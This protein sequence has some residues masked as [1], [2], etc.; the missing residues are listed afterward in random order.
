[1]FIDLFYCYFSCSEPVREFFCYDDPPGAHDS[2]EES[3]VCV[4]N[5]CHLSLPINST[6]VG[7]V[8]LFVQQ[9]CTV[10]AEFFL[11]R[12]QEIYLLENSILYLFQALCETLEE[13]VYD[14]KR[15][16]KE[17]D[18]RILLLEEEVALH[19]AEVENLRKSLRYSTPNWISH[20][21]LN[22]CKPC[23]GVA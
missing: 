1:M 18:A 3:K 13:K 5:C 14:L 23:F 19:K 2:L 17:K 12:N 11:T 4:C 8:F 16:L 10:T 7:M 15:A 9:E 22:C 21:I 20:H 6:L